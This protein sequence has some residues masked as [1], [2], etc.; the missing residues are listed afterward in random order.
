MWIT[1]CFLAEIVVWRVGSSI[2]QHAFHYWCQ[3][4]YSPTGTIESSA[5]LCFRTIGSL[6]KKGT[7]C[8]CAKLIPFQLQPEQKHSGMNILRSWGSQN[9]YSDLWDVAL[10]GLSL[11]LYPNSCQGGILHF[12]C[13]AMPVHACVGA[14]ALCEHE[15]QRH[16]GTDVMG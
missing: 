16:L 7:K 10:T 3:F 6:Q 9:Q 8:E 1:Y 15:C 11:C 12:C 13:P 4:W 2:T 14:L 5:L